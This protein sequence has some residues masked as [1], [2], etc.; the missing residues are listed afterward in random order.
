MGFVLRKTESDDVDFQMDEE[1]SA[2]GAIS[3]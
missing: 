1:G 3:L 2:A